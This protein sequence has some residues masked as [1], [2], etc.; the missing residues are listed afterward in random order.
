MKW[1]SKFAVICMALI[2]FLA[3]SS[4]TILKDFFLWIPFGLGW[5]AGTYLFIVE[6]YP[7]LL[8]L[9]FMLYATK[10]T[11]IY[12]ALLI[13]GILFFCFLKFLWI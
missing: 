6:Y 12:W 10:W 13:F 11:R 3:T 9:L 5:F 1:V 7:Y 2:G 8:S 4:V